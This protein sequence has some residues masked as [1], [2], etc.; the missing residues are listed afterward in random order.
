MVEQ[1]GGSSQTTQTTETAPELNPQEQFLKNLYQKT[2]DWLTKDQQGK[3][4][5]EFPSQ[6]VSE[7]SEHDGRHPGEVSSF[8][9]DLEKGV[10]VET[11]DRIFALIIGREL[12]SRYSR[13]RT[14]SLRFGCVPTDWLLAKDDKN[15][16]FTRMLT[17]QKM[18]MYG[19]GNFFVNDVSG[20]VTIDCWA[21][22]GYSGSKEIGR[23]PQEEL[24]TDKGLT[25]CLD[26]IQRTSR[27][28]F[29]G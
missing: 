21:D 19:S 26:I 23:W 8:S 27:N 29:I 24:L 4:L 5:T 14:L 20:E 2:L 6:Y 17:H 11:K 9:I 3:I 12:N 28:A 13:E 16:K 22:R 25:A 7:W 10:I 18:G 1:K 15:I